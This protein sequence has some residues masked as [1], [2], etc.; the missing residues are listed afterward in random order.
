MCD[1]KF[2]FGVSTHCRRLQAEAQRHRSELP[3]EVCISR[4]SFSNLDHKGYEKTACKD[5]ISLRYRPRQ[6]EYK[7]NRNKKHT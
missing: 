3:L 5:Q 2:G 6:S 7:K 1:V 4:L